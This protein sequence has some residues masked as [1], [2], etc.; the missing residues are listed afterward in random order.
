MWC[1]SRASE[2][3]GKACDEPNNQLE[4]G[5]GDGAATLVAIPPDDDELLSRDECDEG[6]SYSENGG[7]AFD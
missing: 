7:A 1:A 3:T 6:V 5:V 2:G 4:A